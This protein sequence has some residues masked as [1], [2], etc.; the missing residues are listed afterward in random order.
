MDTLK[1][2]LLDVMKGYAG[3]GL[4]GVSYLTYDDEHNIFT[5]VGIATLGKERIVDNDLV[6]RLVGDRIVI[7]YDVNDKP[8]YEALM[9]AGFPRE[10]II[11]AYAGETV[12]LPL[13]S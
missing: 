6:V 9:Q 5:V 8:L 10:Q 11:L 2:S 12:D 1:Q 3:E 4:N 13:T 7:E